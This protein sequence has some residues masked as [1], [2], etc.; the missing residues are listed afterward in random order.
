M[1]ALLEVARMVTAVIALATAVVGLLERRAR[2]RRR[3]GSR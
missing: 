1:D 3:R 2:P